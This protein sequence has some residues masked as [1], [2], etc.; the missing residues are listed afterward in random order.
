MRRA[1]PTKHSFASLVHNS[2]SV[3]GDLLKWADGSLTTP[4]LRQRCRNIVRDNLRLG[5]L[6]DPVLVRMGN[7]GGKKGSCSQ[8]SQ[9]DLLRCIARCGIDTDFAIA[10]C[11]AGQ[12]FQRLVLPHKILPLLFRRFEAKSIIS[13]GACEKLCFD[14]LATALGK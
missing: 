3:S 14:F 13:F 5:N 9:R 6:S 12:Q 4:A 2:A 7:I 8:N 11:D 1:R 10:E